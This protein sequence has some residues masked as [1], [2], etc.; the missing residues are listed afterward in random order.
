MSEKTDYDPQMGA[1]IMVA[2]LYAS[3]VDIIDGKQKH[4]VSL[5]KHELTVMYS[6]GY[7]DGVFPTPFSCVNRAQ[8]T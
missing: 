4:I 2:G 3:I 7:K 5:S 8:L 6:I 1:F